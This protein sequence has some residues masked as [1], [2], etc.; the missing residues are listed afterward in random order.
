[1]DY[2]IFQERLRALMDSRGYNIKTLAMEIGMAEP[3]ISRY[4]T[5]GRTPDLPYIVKLAGFFDVS[6]DWI[7][8]IEAERYEVLPKELREV[9][10]LYS[11]ASEDDR[12]VVQA[13]LRKYKKE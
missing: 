9:A 10:S 5:G 12:R 3:T 11:A 13:V 2:T 6:T 8:G 7:L 4:L 1:M